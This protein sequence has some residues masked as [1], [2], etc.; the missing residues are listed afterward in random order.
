MVD[1]QLY[2]FHANICKA[3]SHPKR[4]EILDHLKDG[5]KSVNEL[6]VLVCVDQPATS[7]YL[8]SLRHAGLVAMHRRGTNI[9]YELGDP[10]IVEACEMMRRYLLERIETMGKLAQ[11]ANT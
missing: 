2:E 3:L 9:Y 11:V 5:E 1:Q 6:M 8:G 7:R 10:K 4:L